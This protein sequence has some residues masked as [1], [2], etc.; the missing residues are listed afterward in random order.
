MDMLRSIGKQS[1]ES[2]ES[3]L[4]KKKRLRWEGL[5]EEKVFFACNE[6]ARGDGWWERWVDGTDGGCATQQITVLSVRS[7]HIHDTF[8][9]LH[10]SSRRHCSMEDLNFTFL[11]YIEDVTYPPS[12]LSVTVTWS[13]NWFAC[14]QRS[15]CTFVVLGCHG[16]DP[17]VIEELSS[18]RSS[19]ALVRP[20]VQIWWR[21]A[22]WIFR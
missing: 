1:G 11:I 20:T 5:A 10:L 15:T 21:S 18:G 3:V 7:Q 4:K 19:T 6:R 17:W 9:T 14:L 22:R 12:H 2:V 16:N 8:Y 13:V